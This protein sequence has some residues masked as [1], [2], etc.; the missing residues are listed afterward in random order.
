MGRRRNIKSTRTSSTRRLKC[1]R[2][3]S[4]I[5][6]RATINNTITHTISANYLCVDT[7]F[8]YLPSKFVG[9]G[10]FHRIVSLAFL[11]LL[12]V[13]CWIN[14]PTKGATPLT[15]RQKNLVHK[16]YARDREGETAYSAILCD[17]PKRSCYYC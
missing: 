5:R 15:K 11:F 17:S 3:G 1:M 12:K 7:F 4:V 9:H 16:K 2:N 13:R 14:R 6:V 10:M 8:R